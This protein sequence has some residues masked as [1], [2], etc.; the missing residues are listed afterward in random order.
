[1]SKERLEKLHKAVEDNPDSAVAHMKLGT[2]LY[3]NGV[4]KRAEQEFLRAIELD[5][6]YAEAWVHL[7]G[8]RLACWDFQGCVDANGRAVEIN[9]ELMQAHYNQGLGFLYLNKPTEMVACFRRV[10]EL[11]PEHPGGHYH[12]AVGLLAAG[13]NV[14]AQTE[15][16]KAVNLG[17][18][19]QPEF[20]KALDRAS[21]GGVTA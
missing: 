9:P 3:W 4:L 12:L 7:G 13:E 16:A 10:V 19:P 20:V 2:A 15:L 6:G 14:E 8:V 21:R 18:A 1:V 17:Y 11:D 5:E